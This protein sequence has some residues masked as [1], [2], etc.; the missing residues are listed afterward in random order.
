MN[1]DLRIARAA[2]VRPITEI[3][4]KLGLR[5]DELDLYGDT[6]AKVKLSVL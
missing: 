1:D 2:N 5:F 6:K 3:A 4:D